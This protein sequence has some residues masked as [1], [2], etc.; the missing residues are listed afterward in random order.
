[1]IDFY[2]QMATELTQGAVVLATVTQVIGSAPRELG[3]KM[4]VCPGGKLIGTIG[5][6]AGE[7]RA[8][9]RALQILVS[10][11]KQFVEIDLSGNPQRETQGV[12]GG[13]MQVWLERWPQES[14]PLVRQ[15]LQSLE[16]HQTA[17]LVTPFRA[18]TSPY[19]LLATPVESTQVTNES[20]IEP[21]IAPPTLLIVGAGHVA[22]PLASVAQ[23]A[24]FQV[25]VTDDRP[26]FAVPER[27]P[28]GIKV[29]ATPVTQA[30]NS[31]PPL[32]Q[33]YAA[34]VT[35]GY[36]HDLEPLQLLLQRSTRYI[37][38]IGSRKRVQRVQQAL[39]EAGYPPTQ[40]DQIYAPIGLDIGALTPAEIA[41]SI[42]AELIQVRRGG[43]GNPLSQGNTPRTA[44]KPTH[45]RAQ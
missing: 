18:G 19:L 28:A 5:G 44:D 4:L 11:E 35:R 13:R 16:S 37:G 21:L 3:A 24:G 12:C 14:L 30:L 1:M 34:L 17:A 6:G 29:L 20:L 33:L 8:C 9:D 26:E 32:P 25:I 36:L 45:D 23:M 7:A 10:G 2:Q 38:M 40:L 41:I 15:I 39:L 27:F 42:C 22:V 43:T 31:I